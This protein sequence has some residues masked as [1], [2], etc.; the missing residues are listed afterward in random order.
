MMFPDHLR[1]DQVIDSIKVSV[2][3][4]H[5]GG[6]LWNPMITWSDKY[7]VFVQLTGFDGVIGIANAG[8]WTPARTLWS[9]ICGPR[10]AR[11]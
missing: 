9:P 6:K 7:S 4:V 5:L 8:V 11:A 2:A 10:F 3:V 1:C